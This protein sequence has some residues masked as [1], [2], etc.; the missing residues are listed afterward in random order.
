MLA[1]MAGWDGGTT[2]IAV[3]SITLSGASG[4][5]TINYDNGSLQLS[6]AILPANATNQTVAWSVVNGT[7]QATISSAGLLTAVTNGTVTARATANDGS[8]IY[9]ELV[10]NISNQVLPVTGIT[11]SGIGGAT[12]ITT[13]NG[14]LQ[15]SAAVL[16]VN[17]TNKTVTWS[18][19]NGT[20]QATISSAGLLTAVTNGTVT[21]RA[22]AN[23]GSGVY[24]ILVITIS[25]HV[26]YTI[27][28]SA[29]IGGSLAPVGTILVDQG[30]NRTYTI[31]A[32]SGYQISNVIVDGV[33]IGVVSSFTFTNITSNH[34]I[35]ASFSAITTSNVALNKPATCQS[36]QAVSLGASNAND[37]NSY[38]YW[39]ADPYPQWWQ[40]DLENIYNITSIVIRNYVDNR[41]YYNYIIESSLDGLSYTE[42][43]R[44]TNTNPATDNG[45][46]YNLSTTA[47][48]LKVT[49]IYNS[50][51]RGAH[52]SDFKVYGSMAKQIIPVT[53][54]TLAAAGGAT[55]IT[56]A[57][58]S[59]QLS[60]AILPAN[61]TNQTVAWSVVNG[62]GQATISSA[63]LLTAVT[64][65]TVTAR[66]TAND[67]SG[68]YGELVINISNQVLPVTGI[69]VSGIGGATAITTANGTLQLSAAVLPVNA[70]NKTVTWSVVNGTGQAT[71]SS[72][73]LLTAVTNGTVTARAT[74]NDGSGVYGIL[75]ITISS[76]VTYTISGS[77]GIGG[78]LAPVGTILVDQGSNRTYT[79]TANS[80]YQISNVIVDGVSIGVVSSFTFTNI[81]SNHTIAASF[82]AITTSNVAL[83]KPATCQSYQAVSLGASNANDDNS[84][85]YWSADPYPQ[86]WQ[87]DLEN[88]YNITS[89]VIRNYVDN[90]R[91]YNYIIESSLDGLSYTEIARKTNT[92]PATDNGDI[93]NLSTTARYLKVTI[94]YNSA[95]RG[96]HISDFQV[97]GNLSA[98]KGSYT[99]S[100]SS[101]KQD[102]IE[103]DFLLKTIEGE[104]KI[105]VYPN[106]FIEEFTIRIDSHYEEP[107]D[108]SVCTLSGKIL[109]IFTQIPVNTENKFSMK[110]RPGI[111]LLRL[112]N[113]EKQ[114]IL[115]ILK[116]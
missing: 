47:R 45:D 64:N 107:F 70:T 2:S 58:G 12:A 41:R 23:D 76:H 89:I 40:V 28:G 116:V 11:V 83:N 5:T 6:A 43:A 74:A 9:G 86:W 49:I 46:I 1:R 110:L 51:N 30:S 33:S 57:N 63:G 10:I 35:A 94:I 62:T 56:S 21:A 39:S 113:K 78:S 87:V 67:G 84:Y 22:T 111:Y 68:I 36:Y 100:L 59:L 15:L 19:V 52:I 102:K 17:A 73:G 24:G 99:D 101:L 31:T 69:T 54:I 77:A 60:A 48:Y 55:T 112:N 91:Y 61:A 106:P 7:G 114:I 108:L 20:G 79:I 75:V 103:N 97:Y 53:G 32:N 90:R 98:S 71:I 44:K 105:S 3:T 104:M 42:I 95:N 82:S 38:S 93:Y 85:S 72:A 16:P 8:G 26:T 37:D 96:A 92:N 65:G 27:S 29:G 25:S 109:Y 18:V 81:T 80:G 88:I 4:F 13:A 115:R 14:T 66:A 34:T 50:A